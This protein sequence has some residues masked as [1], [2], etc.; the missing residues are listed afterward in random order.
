MKLDIFEN[1]LTPNSFMTTHEIYPV[2]LLIILVIT[3]IGTVSVS[4][5]FYKS[6][7]W[8][9]WSTYKI[10]FAYYPFTCLF[11]LFDPIGIII[12]AFF[13]CLLAART[14]YVAVAYYI[15]L[16]SVLMPWMLIPDALLLITVSV[17]IHKK[18]NR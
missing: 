13:I 2:L 5:S 16:H 4:I 9:E 17:I 18:I 7:N 15:Y 12:L 3:L 11:H 14:I 10:S 8:K 6:W 1:V